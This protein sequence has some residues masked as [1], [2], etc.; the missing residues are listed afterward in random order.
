MTQGAFSCPG[1]PAGGAVPEA[2]ARDRFPPGIELSYWR[3]RSRIVK[4]RLKT[5]TNS[6]IQGGLLVFALLALFLRFSV[7]VWVCVGIPIAFAGALALLLAP[8][9]CQVPPPGNDASAPVEA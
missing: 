8:V 1:A 9:A 6:A 7:A 5:L 2:E 4:S 3:D